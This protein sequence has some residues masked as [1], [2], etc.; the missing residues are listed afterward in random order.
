M[1][2]TSL[3]DRRAALGAGMIWIGATA[4][5]A[6]E[7]AAPRI[8][9][10]DPLMDP[11][12]VG[13]MRAVATP[14]DNAEEIKAI[15]RQLLC[16]CGCNLDIFTCRTTDFTCTTSPALHNEI[17]G[18]YTAGQTADQIIAAFVAKYGEQS[19]LAPRAAGFNLLGYLLP[20]FSVVAAVGLLGFLLLRRHRQRILAVAPATPT[21]AGSSLGPEQQRALA[22]ALQDV[23]R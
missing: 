15:E 21:R 19:L 22:E 8:G 18:M 13:Q 1:S 16:T 23:E 14:L 7:P 2:G 4:L 6:Q 20:G 11:S 17:V 5:R 9:P 12:R 3:M 10:A